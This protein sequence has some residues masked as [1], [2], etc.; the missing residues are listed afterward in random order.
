MR[1][2]QVEKELDSE[3]YV[4][5]MLAPTSAL[6]MLTRLIKL[7]GEPLSL[8]YGDSEQEVAKVL[9]KAVSAL[10]SRLDENQ[11]E[12]LVKDLLK[13]VVYHNQPLNFELHFQGRLGHLFK[14]LA[15]VLEV[16]YGDFLGAMLA[17]GGKPSASMQAPAAG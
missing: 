11:V 5:T 8:L 1:Q 3:K 12:G 17:V 7:I 2:F 9:P 14:L 15:A 4:I 10:V 13:C 6:K 16:Q